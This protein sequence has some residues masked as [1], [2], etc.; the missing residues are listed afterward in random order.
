LE[1]RPSYAILA[2]PT[3]LGIYRGHTGW[4]R[5]DIVVQGPN[6]FDV[7]DAAEAIFRE[8]AARQSDTMEASRV[9][10]QSVQRPRF[11]AW[12]GFRRGVIG[13]SSRLRQEEDSVSAGTM[14][15]RQAARVAES[16]SQVS[17]DVVIPR[18]KQQLY[19]NRTTLTE[20]RV[21]AWEMD[22]YHPLVERAR[23]VLAAA[24]REPRVGKWSLPRIGMGTA[25]SVLSREFQVPVIGYGPGVE[26]DCHAPNESVP[27][28]NIVDATNDLAA[29]CHGL[30]GVP[31]CGWTA[32]EI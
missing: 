29:I 24:G 14:L 26:Q 6:P 17:V 27:V 22:A 11:E 25:G 32:D 10:E 21:E 16:V 8:L 12:N 19:T 9:E 18:T 7:D 3:D 1:I 23:Q 4:A 2:E 31:V 13:I 30:V 28:A 5:F 15:K 20:T